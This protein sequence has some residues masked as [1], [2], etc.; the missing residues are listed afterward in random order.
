MPSL[1]E[2]SSGQRLPEEQMCATHAKWQV[3]RLGRKLLWPPVLGTGHKNIFVQI[4]CALNYAGYSDTY[5]HT[6][7]GP[8]K[9]RRSFA[10]D[11]K[12]MEVRNLARHVIMLPLEVRRV[13][14]T[15]ATILGGCVLIFLCANRFRPPLSN[16]ACNR[17]FVHA[18]PKLKR[19]RTLRI[20][21]IQRI[22]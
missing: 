5:L 22:L 16:Q 4:I 17:L 20:R 2:S 21:N 8:A 6:L 15:E 13:L 9:V 12:K 11:I 3:A 18:I 1:E 19:K 14:T 7:L 10:Q